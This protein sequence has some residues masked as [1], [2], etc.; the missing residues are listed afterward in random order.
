MSKKISIKAKKIEIVKN[1]P[2]LKLV[3][4][5]QVFLSFANFYQQFIQGFNRIVTPLTSIL[6]ITGLS[7]KP[8]PSRNNCSKS[9]F[10][11]NNNSWPISRRNDGNTEVD[12]FG[13]GGDGIEH[14]KKSKKSKSQKSFKS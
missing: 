4:D 13:I 14:A 3:Q 2:E 10:S 7:D 6:K 8:A 1:W 11:R 9:T 12:R 5:I